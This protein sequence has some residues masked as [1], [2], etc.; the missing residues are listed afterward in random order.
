M[1]FTMI[2][3]M[4]FNII[5][6]FVYLIQ[7]RKDKQLFIQELILIFLLCTSGCLLFMDR[8]IYHARKVYLYTGISFEIVNTA[9]KWIEFNIT[10]Y[11][12]WFT[13]RLIQKFEATPLKIKI[14]K[15]NQNRSQVNEQTPSPKGQKSKIE[16]K[17]DS[18]VPKKFQQNT[19][20]TSKNDFD[21]GI[22][23]NFEL[24]W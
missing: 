17:A 22:Y 19:I 8:K 23:S 13:L 20:I 2:S 6:C 24:P 5:G 14:A 1:I 3:W 9:Q 18:N 12:L 11:I 7:I 21:I 4:I 16:N 10:I 15:C